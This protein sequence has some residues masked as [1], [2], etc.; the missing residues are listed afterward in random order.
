M[1]KTKRAFSL[2]TGG[3]LLESQFEIM[4]QILKVMQEI[5]CEK[6]THPA[7]DII[8]MSYG[9]CYDVNTLK[10]RPSNV[11]LTLCAGWEESIYFK[12]INTIYIYY[13]YIIQKKVWLI[14]IKKFLNLSI[15]NKTSN[16][17]YKKNISASRLVL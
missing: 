11:V 17:I 2:L 10:R 5:C 3:L 1:Y 7:H 9:R 16:F 14:E 4:K 12:S 15:N 13:L 8:M 6:I